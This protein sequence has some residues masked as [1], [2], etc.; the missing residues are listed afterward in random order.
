MRCCVCQKE[1]PPRKRYCDRC[2]VHI[3]SEDRAKRRA[4]LIEAYDKGSDGFRC[5][6]SN[7]LVEER[8]LSDPFYI[9]FDHLIPIESS[10]L[11][12]SSALFN[13]MK[14][15]LGPDE[16][17]LAFKLLASHHRGS[18]FEKDLLKFEY[19]HMRAPSPMGP[20]RRLHKAELT[21]VLVP[22]CVICGRPPR[23]LSMYCPQCRRIVLQKNHGIRARAT[24]LKAAWSSDEEGFLCY[25]TG[26]KLDVDDP[27]SPWSLSFDHRIPGEDGTLAVA[28]WWVNT[29]KTALSEQEFWSVVTEYDRYLREG[30]EFDRDVAEFKYWRRKGRP[31]P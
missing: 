13:T 15:E 18:P 3:K 4:A 24:A 22:K 10:K 19:W 28:A 31:H 21:K 11:V 30:G 6:W 7:L 12:V 14:K 27:F 20:E 1:T 9:C 25:Y 8:D 26:I 29:M 2:H 5:H 23:R 17:P 16:F